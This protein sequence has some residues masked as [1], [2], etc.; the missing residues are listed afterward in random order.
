LPPEGAPDAAL[1]SPRTAELLRTLA[2]L[3]DASALE[4]ELSKR[5]CRWLAAR[6]ADDGSWSDGRQPSEEERIFTTGMVAGHLAK[7]PFVRHTSLAAAA[8]HLFALWDPDRLKG[9][10]WAATAA[11][12]HCFALVRHNESDA[13]LQWC[14]REL[15][16]GFRTGMYDA[17][18]VSRVL[19]WCRAHGLPGAKLGRAELVECLLAEQD[20]DGGFTP[21]TD[22]APRRRVAHTVDALAGLVR[23]S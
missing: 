17:V 14:G 5:V 16:R 18:R 15:D 7:T 8:D 23:L 12:S 13:I 1:D 10:A 11:Y 20:E 2:G 3:D 4:G 21:G 22:V 19:G 6:Q 9:S